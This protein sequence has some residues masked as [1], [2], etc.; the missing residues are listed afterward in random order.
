MLVLASWPK[1]LVGS[2]FP[3]PCVAIIPDLVCERPSCG[4]L[5]GMAPTDMTMRS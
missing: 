5:M 1:S 2:G 3:A 4:M